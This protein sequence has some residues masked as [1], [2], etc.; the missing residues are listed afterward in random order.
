MFKF[1]AKFFIEGFRSFLCIHPD[2]ADHSYPFEYAPKSIS[3]DERSINRDFINS[4]M[5]YESKK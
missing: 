5:Q 2:E 4:I 3:S 1:N